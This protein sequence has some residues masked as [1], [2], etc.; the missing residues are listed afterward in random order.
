MPWSEFRV[1]REVYAF[2]VVPG[3]ADFIFIFPLS[4]I[5]SIY[6]NET[7]NNDGALCIEL[8]PFRKVEMIPPLSSFRPLESNTD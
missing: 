7:S 8:D 1:R 4:K 3:I 2:S 5:V 6:L